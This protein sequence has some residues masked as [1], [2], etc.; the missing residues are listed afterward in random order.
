MGQHLEQGRFADAV[1]A[2]DADSLAGV[3][4]EAERVEDR[5]LA[6]LEAD[7]CGSNHRRLGKR[8]CLGGGAVYACCEAAPVFFAA[9]IGRERRALTLARSLCG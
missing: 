5:L 1:A 7:V 3:D 4:G 6:A 2:D 9:A 8:T